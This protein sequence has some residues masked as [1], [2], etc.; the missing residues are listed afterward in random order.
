MK[1][2]DKIKPSLKRTSEITTLQVNLGKICNLACSHCHV[3]AS[4]K[5]TESMDEHTI[6][7]V[8]EALRAHK[9]HTLDVTGGAPEMNAHFKRLVSE[10][11]KMV[12]HIIVRTNLTILDEAGYE[13][14]IDFYVANA[15]EIVASLP[16]YTKEN[17]DKMRGNGVFERSIKILKAL[18]SA[19]YAKKANLV[20]N[21][22]Y[23][24]LGAFL[25]GD[26]KELENDYK[27]QL[28]EGYGVEFNSLFTISNVPI[29]RF[30]TSLEKNGE[31][32]RYM[33]LLKDNYNPLAAQ[34]IMCRSQ[35]SVGYDGA[36][37]DCDFNQME[38]LKANGA[39]DIF[40]F[41]Q[42]KDTAREIVFK[43]YCYACTAGAGSSCGGALA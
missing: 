34:N 7:A 4:P 28:K 32:E 26:Q 18:N 6:K 37:Y 27:K 9:F 30:K 21:L 33:K 17:T 14:F 36:I 11:R 5:R 29:G 25:P 1:F 24:P 8:L 22:V 10:A 38:G 31:L 42:L 3:Q 19:G 43:D 40:E 23:N 20:L 13:D 39:R 41:A 2:E 12:P 35:I 16:C 15:V